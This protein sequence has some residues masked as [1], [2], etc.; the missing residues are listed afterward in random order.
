[1]IELMEVDLAS[2]HLE[3]LTDEHNR[4]AISLTYAVQIRRELEAEV[5]DF[6]LW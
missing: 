3:L 5:P 4:I 6:E 1:M 2:R